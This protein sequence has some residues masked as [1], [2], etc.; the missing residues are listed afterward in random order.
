MRV[1]TPLRRA[2]AA[3]QLARSAKR[4]KAACL[5]GPLLLSGGRWCN[6]VVR[7]S[8][9]SSTVRSARMC[10][11]LCCRRSSSCWH[12]T[13]CIWRAPA[14]CPCQLRSGGRSM[15]A[16]SVVDGF[17]IVIRVSF[18]KAGSSDRPWPCHSTSPVV[19][20]M[21]KHS[22]RL[23]QLMAG[24]QSSGQSVSTLYG[25]V[26]TLS[27]SMASCFLYPTHASVWKGRAGRRRPRQRTHML[28]SS[29]RIPTAMV[30]RVLSGGLLHPGA[31][32]AAAT[33]N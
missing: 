16:S 21:R 24:I 22:A 6:C 29:L 26:H 8:V 11:Q 15:V 1:L 23:R 13:H 20:H 33:C 18:R 3:A 19:Q 30:K 9:Q 28:W 10:S 27:S 5:H 31:E 32:S 17:R 4:T 12:C 2:A 14:P 25:G 7:S